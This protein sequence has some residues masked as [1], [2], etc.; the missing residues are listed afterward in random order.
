[1]FQADLDY[2][3]KENENLGKCIIQM[4]PSMKESVEECE[5]KIEKNKFLLKIICKTDKFKLVEGLSRK[6]ADKLD[7]QML[8]C[9]KELREN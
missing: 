7:K 6:S 3:T 9:M 2:M 8:D 4:L 5:T 1:M